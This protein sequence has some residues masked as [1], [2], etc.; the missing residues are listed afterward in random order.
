MNYSSGYE[1]Q[2]FAVIVDEAED[3]ELSQD[4]GSLIAALQGR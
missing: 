1:E 4:R 2:R 3:V